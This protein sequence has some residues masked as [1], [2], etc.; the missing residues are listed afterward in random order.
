[1]S[2]SLEGVRDW[3]L[4]DFSE[5][6]RMTFACVQGCIHGN[7]Q[8]C[9]RWYM[10]CNFTWQHFFEKSLLKSFTFLSTVPMALF[11]QNQPILPFPSVCLIGWH[12][13]QLKQSVPLIWRMLWMLLCPVLRAQG[14]RQHPQWAAPW[15]QN[16]L[17]NWRC[18]PVI[19][20]WMG[21][22]RRGKGK[23]PF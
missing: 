18:E 6:T 9:F 17:W 7:T 15:Q 23:Y 19:A 11:Q 21:D 20:V 8:A 14:L 1:M 12:K 4:W 10:A 22:G 16:S 5:C 2:L 3:D 13:V